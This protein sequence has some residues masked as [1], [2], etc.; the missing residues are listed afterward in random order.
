MKGIER[1]VRPLWLAV[2]VTTLLSSAPAG[3]VVTCHRINAR[4][5]GQINF[6]S[7]S[8]DGVFKG[9]GQ[10]NGTTHGD[11]EFTGINTYEG[12]FTVTARHGTLTLFLFDGIFDATTGEFSNDSVVI[13]GTGRFE[14]ATG[15]IFFEGVVFPDGSYTD[16]I[17]G[18][19]CLVRE[20]DD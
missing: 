5:E 7:N 2:I 6:E 16:D 15:G 4:G 17:T 13:A 19:I 11:F 18:E 1:Q 10:L 3:A 14:D 20:D 8:S 9:A 12:V